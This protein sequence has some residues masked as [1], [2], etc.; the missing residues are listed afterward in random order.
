MNKFYIGI[1]NGVSGSVGVISDSGKAVWF[2]MPVKN[3]LSYTKTKKFINRVDIPALAELFNCVV[4]L[5]ADIVCRIERPMVNPLRFNAT[6]SA[7]R[8]LEAVQIF[9]EGRKVPYGFIDS[10]E[11]Q[12]RMLPAG[13]Q[14]SEE[15]KAAADTV[16][17]R[18]FPSISIKAGGGD[19]LLIAQYLKEK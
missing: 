12:K 9:L 1:D 2:K 15:L 10:K 6:L 14:G 13:L 17:R 3:E 8:A 4:P 18:L 16:C 11:W 19:S 7:M 5:D